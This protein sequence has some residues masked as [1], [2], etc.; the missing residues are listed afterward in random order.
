MSRGPEG[1]RAGASTHARGAAAEDA[2][3]EWLEERGFEILERNVRYDV[4]EIDVVAREGETLC[5]IEVKARL[6][7]TYGS[8]L[9]AVTRH[10][11]RRLLRA[12]SLYL[13]DRSWPGPCRFDVLGM[14]AEGE[15]WRVELVRD[16]FQG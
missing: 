7:G 11:Q 1:F 5:F 3:A 6:D 15:A 2:A 12:A 14:V 16:A 8:P 4:G 9:E 10:R 13:V